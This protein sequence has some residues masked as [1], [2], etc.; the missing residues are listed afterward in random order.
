MF[1]PATRHSP[2][3]RGEG[4]GPIVRLYRSPRSP[5]TKRF[6]PA[7]NL[8]P[9]ALGPSSAAARGVGKTPRCRL[10]SD[11]SRLGW[12]GDVAGG[13]GTGAS[14]H[15]SRNRGHLAEL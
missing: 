11:T 3:A 9:G 5:A 12:A 14:L 15:G 2:R 7:S 8:F 6:Q 1:L 10:D 13:L 4:W